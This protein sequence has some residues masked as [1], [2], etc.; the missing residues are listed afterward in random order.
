M[1]PT[2]VSNLKAR[3]SGW[4]DLCAQLL[5]RIRPRMKHAIVRAAAARGCDSVQSLDPPDGLRKVTRPIRPPRATGSSES[6]PVAVTGAR[7]NY[8]TESAKSP[9]IGL[10][11]PRC[12]LP[13]GIR[14]PHSASNQTSRVLD[15]GTKVVAQFRGQTPPFSA[16]LHVRNECVIRGRFWEYC[17]VGELEC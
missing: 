2:L 3:D 17:E 8:W 10:L 14:P 6:H 13:R 16:G 5:R 1:K 11:R 15:H 12:K 7:E 9:R 4:F